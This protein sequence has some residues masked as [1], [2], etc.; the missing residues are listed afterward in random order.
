MVAS[1]IKSPAR[2]DLK[3]LIVEIGGAEAM[4][5]ILIDFYARM[6]Q[7]VMIG[8][9]FEGKDL[10]HIAAQQAAFILNAAGLTERFEGK[11]PSSAH[12]ELAPILTGH[13]DRRLQILRETLAA[14]SVPKSTAEKWVQ[15]EESFRKIVV[16]N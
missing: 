13:F 15:F 6:G 5:Q 1:K 8:F 12:V 11:G 14:H 3:Q 4:T 10:H 9:F 16:S 2:E 7:D